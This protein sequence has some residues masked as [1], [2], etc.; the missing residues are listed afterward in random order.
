MLMSQ[1]TTVHGKRHT[2]QTMQVTRGSASIGEFSTQA[3][4]MRMSDRSIFEHPDSS[5]LI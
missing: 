3:I 4:S 5:F 2:V 1:A